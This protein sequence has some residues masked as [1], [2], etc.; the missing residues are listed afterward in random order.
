[1]GSGLR[2]VTAA[3]LLNQARS[4]PFL[5]YSSAPVKYQLVSQISTQVWL[6]SFCAQDGQPAMRA[7]T[8]TARQASTRIMESPVQVARPCSMDSFGLWLVRL[9]RVL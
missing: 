3:S 6:P 7:G 5:S 8:P 4:R 9:R 2:T 1:M